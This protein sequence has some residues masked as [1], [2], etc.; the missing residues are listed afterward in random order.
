MPTCDHFVYTTAKTNMKTGYQIVAKSSG[1]NERILN[2]MISYFFPLGVDPMGFKK[3]KSLLP[4]GKELIAYSTVKNIGI[5]YDGRDGTLYNH[6]IILKKDDFEKIEYDT[7]VL[8]KFFIEDYDI[9]GE[10]DQLYIQPEKMDLDFE[11]LKELEDD[12]VSTVLFYLFKKSKIAIIK[13]PDDKL[14]QNIL[15]IIPPQIRFMPFSTEVLEPPRQTKYQLIQIPSKVQPKL[16]SSYVTINPDM[17]PDSKIKQAKDIGIKNIIELIKENNQKELFKLHR[18]FEKI[19]LQVSK[20]KRIKVK[21][22]FDKE[23]FERLAEK[24][25]F[26]MLLR[27]VKNL[28]SSPAFNQA[29]PRTIL[30]ITKKIR[31]IIKKSFKEHEKQNLRDDDFEKLISISKILLDCLNY[32]KQLSEKKM[33]DSTQLEVE[34]EI[35]TIELILK[36]HPQ[37]ESIIQEYSFN[38]SEYFTTICENVVYFAYSMTLYVLGRKWW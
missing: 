3:S 15:S 37:A 13:T 18:D 1:I 14:L 30:T 17:I 6:T 2:S 21:D 34:N 33:G 25:R 23:G 12:F 24:R 35:E 8:D 38:P 31:K 20:I 26:N 36:Q 29:S 7:R 10:I 5:G 11:Y 28:Y 4:I 22:I 32:I 9:R 27:N 19:A 16:Q